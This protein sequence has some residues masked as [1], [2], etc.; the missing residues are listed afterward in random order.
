MRQ[1]ISNKNFFPLSVATSSGNMST[2][3]AAAASGSSTNHESQPPPNDHSNNH[4]KVSV[5]KFIAE[6]AMVIVSARG[7]SICITVKHLVERL[8]VNPKVLE[9]DKAEEAAGGYNDHRILRLIHL[10]NLGVNASLSIKCFTV[11]HMQH[12]PAATM[13]IAFSAINFSTLFFTPL[14]LWSQGGGCDSRLVDL[15]LAAAAEDEI[16]L[17]LLVVA[18]GVKKFLLEIAQHKVSKGSRESGMWRCRAGWNI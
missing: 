15:P 10:Q 8:C 9:V 12:P 3:S 2:S 18:D 11:I 5:A 6:N 16:M 7:C 4:M 17:P 1:T 13:T 14:L